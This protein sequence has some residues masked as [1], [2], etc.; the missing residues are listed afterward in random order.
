M[1]IAF[2]FT[3]LVLLFTACTETTPSKPL[4]VKVE[5][6]H[7]LGEWKTV[8]TI[9]PSMAILNIHSDSTF[10]YEVGACTY[11]A[12]SKGTWKLEGAI[13]ELNSSP[14]DSCMNIDFFEEDCIMIDPLDD[15]GPD[16]TIKKPNCEGINEKP[17]FL[18]FEREMFQVIC[19]TLVLIPSKPLNCPE[20]RIEFV[21]SFSKVSG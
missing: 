11:S 15:P 12:Y 6:N 18:I 16:R 13:L 17:P 4:P 2:I 1:R 21:R 3:V 8:R 14:P 7:F 9:V 19:D 20:N 5:E 10:D